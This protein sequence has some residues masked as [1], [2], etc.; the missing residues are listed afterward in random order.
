[1]LG[2][3]TQGITQFGVAAFPAAKMVK[4]MTTYNPIA[5]GFIWGAIA[6]FTA[7]NPDDPT[8]TNAITEHL[9]LAPP[10]EREPV[11]RMF[12]AQIEKYENDPELVKRAK[13]ALEGA[14]IGGAVEGIAVVVRG[15]IGI[16]KK[17]PF[18]QVVS[19]ARGAVDTAGQA[20]DQRIAERAG[21]VT[22]GMGVDPS[23]MIDAAV[24]YAGKLARG[25]TPIRAEGGLPIA[26][27]RAANELRLHQGR[28]QAGQEAGKPYPG[29]P[30]NERTVLSAPE[31]SGLPDVTIGAIE[32][33]DWRMRIESAMSPDEILETSQWY[34]KVFG[35]F[36]KQADGDPV[37]IAKLTDAWFAGQ[38]NSSP[39]Q[40]LNDVLFVYEQIKAGVP[41]DE[42]RGKG[43]PSANKIVIDI[44]TSSEITGGA[45]QKISDFLD[46]GYDKNVRS[47]MNNSPDGGA[48]FVLMCIPPVTWA[49]LTKFI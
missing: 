46:S 8:I 13:T 7:F 49:S 41:K 28:I 10:E 35:E 17:I 6:D 9:Q 31:G 12:L 39:S 45:G 20:A 14:I 3:L 16:A 38:Q 19:S 44:L 29:A 2:E 30:K 25:D 37:E 26:E 47:I 1:M 36:Q 33:D 48:P 40:T 42:L 34:K 27:D 21:S 4:A 24:S 18:E 22:L 5:R 11:L 15:A 43:L 32:P 23:G